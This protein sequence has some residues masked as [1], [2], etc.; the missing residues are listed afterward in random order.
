MRLKR[1]T[2]TWNEWMSVASKASG[3]LLFLAVAGLGCWAWCAFRDIGE[4]HD[5]LPTPQNPCRV[6]SVWANP[7]SILIEGYL[8]RT[9]R[10]LHN[11]GETEESAVVPE[12]HQ[13]NSA[14]DS[15]RAGARERGG[16]ERASSEAQSALLRSRAP[17]LPR[18]REDGG[19][20]IENRGSSIIQPDGPILDPPSSILG[21]SP[22]PRPIESPPLPPSS[23]EMEVPPF[24]Q[25][26][27]DAPLGFT[28]PSGILPRDQQEDNHFVPVE[29]RWRIGFPEW[30]RYAKGHPCGADYPYQQVR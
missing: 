20:R 8:A 22:L 19:P 18:F 26:P 7:N 23:Q 2:F 3:W 12:N 24:F 6:R 4:F 16:A 15:A 17:A 25:Y 21:P 29:D 5:P 13:V 27:M 11:A 10:T 14:S 9:E 1:S 30:D 28:G